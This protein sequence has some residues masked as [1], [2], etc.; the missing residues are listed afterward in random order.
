MKPEEIPLGHITHIN[1][2][3]AMIHPQT[4]H[5]VDMNPETAQ[6][7]GAVTALKARQPGL[8]AWIAIGGWAMNDPG[9]YRT[10]FSDMV[11]SDANQNAFFESL[12]KFMQ[13]YD[14]DG[15]D[16][17]WE[18]SDLRRIATVWSRTTNRDLSSTQWQMIAAEFQQTSKI[19]L[20]WCDDSESA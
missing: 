19:T 4:F 15:V 2:A 10:A 14:F 16:L 18:A 13:R 5:V 11:S 12:I 8:Q 17:D 6:L 3:F 7:Y 20:E 1:F 9:P